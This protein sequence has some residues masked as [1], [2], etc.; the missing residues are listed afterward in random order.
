ML[1]SGLKLA[2]LDVHS[3]GFLLY[4]FNIEAPII[5]LE[6]GSDILAVFLFFFPI[7][8]TGLSRLNQDTNGFFHISVIYYDSTFYCTT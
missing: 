4:K 2:N 7:Q 5:E 6:S 3:N 8:N 1:S